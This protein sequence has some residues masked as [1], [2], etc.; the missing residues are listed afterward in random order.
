[1]EKLDVLIFYLVLLILRLGLF[2]VFSLI[3]G[4]FEP[5]C[6]LCTLRRHYKTKINPTVNHILN[7]S[8]L[9]RRHFYQEQMQPASNR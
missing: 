4:D 8:I 1:M 7:D 9:A 6:S 3:F 2:L 5:R